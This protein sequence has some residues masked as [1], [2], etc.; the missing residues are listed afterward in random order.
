MDIFA[1]PDFRRLPEP[2]AALFA[3]A[4]R[5][6][7]FSQAEWY[8]LLARHGL[9]PGAET[10]L[11]MTQSASAKAGLVA[12]FTRSG[13]HREL[14]GLCNFY[15]C[16]YGVL[17]DGESG[18]ALPLVADLAAAIVR[19]ESKLDTILLPGLDV[20]DG[21]FG[22]ILAGLRRAGFVAKPFFDSGTWYESVAGLNFA[23]FTAARPSALRNTWRRKSAALAKAH[24]VAV[25][26]YE[27]GEDIGA[28]LADYDAVYRRSWKPNEPFPAFMPALIRLAA[29]SGALRLGILSLDGTPAA[30]QFW[31]VWQGRAVIYK[32]AY[33]EQF[34]QF[35]PGTL[36][37]MGMVER[38][39][40]RDSLS[41]INFGRG[42]D[43]YKRL[44][45]PR[46]RERWG[47]FAA[48]PRTPRGMLHSARI[49]ASRARDRLLGRDLVARV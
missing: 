6:S 33:D 5:T 30:A 20:D 4:S 44:W 18:S 37:T 10:R 2:A 21:A 32:L 15:S 42:D 9:E 27:P 43:P 46:R 8:D 41:E 48:N 7:F 40:D 29:S 36:L 1:A 12:S 35:S 28:Y 11:Y 23:D 16:E 45:L 13:G 38:A 22:A 25:R 31:I 17:M 49:V 24:T 34:N 26:F 39:L 14:R 3:A 47:I 19:A